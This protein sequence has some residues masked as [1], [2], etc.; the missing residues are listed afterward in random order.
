[1]QRYVEST[2]PNK[3]YCPKPACSQFIN[4]GLL[5]TTEEDFELDCPKCG[6]LICEKCKCEAHGDVSCAEALHNKGAPQLDSMAESNDWR[7]CGKCG[8]FIE[9]V[10]G[11]SSTPIQ[12][13]SRIGCNHMICLC[14]YQFCFECGAEWHTCNCALFSEERLIEAV[15]ARAPETSDEERRHISIHL[16]CLLIFESHR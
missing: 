5:D 9:L 7:K 1:M 12:T 8:N 6:T 14:R 3:M 10:Y 2:A 11:M 16:D 13:D 4:L 15:E